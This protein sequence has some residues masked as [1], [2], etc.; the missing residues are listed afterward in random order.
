MKILYA[1]H[2]DKLI[3]LSTVQTNKYYICL[4]LFE[5]LLLNFHVNEEI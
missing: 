5:E 3:Y 2:A 4:P 1:A